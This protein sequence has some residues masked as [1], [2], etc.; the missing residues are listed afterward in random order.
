MKKVLSFVFAAVLS[1]FTFSMNVSAA[2]GV[3]AKG[4]DL[5]Y[6]MDGS[7]A[8]D[9]KDTVAIL[10]Y[11]SE[12]QTNNYTYLDDEVRAYIAENGDLSGD[13]I[14][15]S[16]DAALLMSYYYSFYEP[17]DVNLDG[18]VDGTDA[19][20]I[21]QYYAIEQTEADRTF[22]K[23]E[24]CDIFTLGDMDGDKVVNSADASAVLK[25]YAEAQNG[26]G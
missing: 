10:D 17:G 13:G 25:K 23:E 3:D 18:T 22:S 15:N 1:C 4:H 9:F 14:I 16:F 5:F 19:S 11:Y 24:M 8:V 2:E 7:G 6:D 20:M 21:M 12:I 26:N